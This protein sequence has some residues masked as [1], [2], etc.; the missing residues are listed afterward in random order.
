MATQS[1]GFRQSQRCYMN[2]D[3]SCCDR[4][5]NFASR[6][7]FMLN[8]TFLPVDRFPV[9]A[10]SEMFIYGLANTTF[11]WSGKFTRIGW[12]NVSLSDPFRFTAFLNVKAKGE[13]GTK[14]TEVNEKRR[15]SKD[16]KRPFATVWHSP[17]MTMFNFNL[18]WSLSLL[19]P[20][21]SPIC[22]SPM[23]MAQP[24]VLVL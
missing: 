7:V 19:H 22:T 1:K 8:G 14:T 9:L 15:K 10:I 5:P 21:T 12:F 2:L 24:P 4:K 23:C 20:I 18:Y 16:P 11:H 6:A 17:Q 3:C 13:P